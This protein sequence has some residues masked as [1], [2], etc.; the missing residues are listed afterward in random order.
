MSS[1][2][3]VFGPDDPDSKRRA[4]AALVAQ[5]VQSSLWRRLKA[6]SPPVPRAGAVAWALVRAGRCDG[7]KSVDAARSLGLLPHA[8]LLMLQRHVH[9]AGVALKKSRGL[10]HASLCASIELVLRDLIRTAGMKRFAGAKVD[11]EVS[12]RDLRRLEWFKTPDGKARL[13][14]IG[15]MLGEDDGRDLTTVE[16][17]ELDARWPMPS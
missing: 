1:F 6:E 12:A 13:A 16:V 5:S 9:G 10:E 3:D 17:A 11:P 4:D 14:R 2:A 15:E 8:D 7:P